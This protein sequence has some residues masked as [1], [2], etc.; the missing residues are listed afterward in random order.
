MLKD[1][2]YSTTDELQL[3]EQL[4]N[5]VVELFPICRSITGNGVRETLAI[6][7]RLLPLE[8]HEVPSGTEVFDWLVPDEWNIRDAYLK[9]SDGQRVIDFQESNLHVLNYS[10]PFHATLPLKKLKEHLFTLPEQVD[11]I[12]YRTAY[13]QP[14]WGLCL[15]QNQLDA[16]AEDDYEVCIDSSLKP[17]SLT[18]AELLIPGELKEE[19]L[20]SCHICHP[21]LAN[22][23]LSGVAIAAHLAQFLQNQTLR[24]SY[25]FVFIPGTIGAITW[26]ARNEATVANIKHGLVLAGL[27][28]PGCLSYKRSRQGETE[29]DQSAAYV[30]RQQNDY[31]LVDFSPYGYDERQYCSPGFNLSVGRLSRTPHGTFPE[32]HTSAD[33]LDFVQ[34]EQL[35]KSMKACLD[36]FDI[37]ENNKYYLNAKPKGEPRLSKYD[38]YSDI[39]GLQVTAESQMAMLWVLNLADGQHNLLDIAQRSKLP[40]ALLVLSVKTLLNHGL[41]KEVK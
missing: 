10:L 19:V 37:L 30:L 7:K 41:L 1:S 28:D 38:L 39:G 5:L 33:N 18:Y 11:L 27:G 21:S 3:G 25:R 14:N 12:P 31:T 6:L 4:H 22:D 32:Y 17:G 15:S 35:A 16:L 23:N 29:I 26:L 24:Y 34:A 2:F 13:Y 9:N 20:I 40:F 36:I 8:I